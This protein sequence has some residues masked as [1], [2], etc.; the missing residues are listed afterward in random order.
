M[1]HWQYTWGSILAVVAASTAGDGL[2]SLAMKQSGDVGKL[3]RYNGLGKTI[4]VILSNSTL[5]IGV[6]FMALAFFA[7]LFALSWA[8]VSLVAPASASLTFIAN[9]IVGKLFLREQVDRRRWLAAMLVAAGVAL[10]A[11]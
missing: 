4:K 3:Y 9:A 7:L 5:W 6:G 10:V 11:R 1:T 2:T 8:D